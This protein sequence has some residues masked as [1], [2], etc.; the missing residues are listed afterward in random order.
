MNATVCLTRKCSASLSFIQFILFYTYDCTHSV[1]CNENNEYIC[2]QETTTRVLVGTIIKYSIW[3]AVVHLGNL[4]KLL[5]TNKALHFCRA[6]KCCTVLILTILDH[7]GNLCSSIQMVVLLLNTVITVYIIP[8][9]VT[10]ISAF[11]ITLSIV[12]WHTK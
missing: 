1:C 6:S 11:F 5:N 12:T 7:I 4:Y 8:G 2:L 10:Q 9:N 3:F